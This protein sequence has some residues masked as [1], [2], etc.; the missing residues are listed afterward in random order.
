MA[1]TLLGLTRSN[2]VGHAF[3]YLISP[4]QVLED[5]MPVVQLQKPVVEFVLFVRPMP[6]LY[7]FSLFLVELML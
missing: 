5:E 1:S 7:I 3:E 6:L 2:K 4:P